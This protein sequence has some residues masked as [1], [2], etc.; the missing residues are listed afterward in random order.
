MP[1]AKY[2][3]SSG[4][5]QSLSLFLSVLLVGSL[6]KIPGKSSSRSVSYS[7]LASQSN[8]S[9]NEGDF[10][11][12]K[13]WFSSDSGRDTIVETDPGMSAPALNPVR[14]RGRVLPLS[15]ELFVQV[16]GIEELPDNYW[17]NNKAYLVSVG[18]HLC[19][20]HKHQHWDQKSCVNQGLNKHKHTGTR[21]QNFVVSYAY[22]MSVKHHEIT[23]QA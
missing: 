11:A 7:E 10:S 8:M 23:A 18:S 6:T 2:I 16:W 14:R 20:K 15:S 12:V 1:W 9:W 13:F 21:N 5:K 17:D 3:I 22:L 4:Q 19:G